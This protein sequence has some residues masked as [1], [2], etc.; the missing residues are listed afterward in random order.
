MEFPSAF[1]RCAGGLGS[2]FF[3]HACKAVSEG[4]TNPFFCRKYESRTIF[5][6]ETS[7]VDDLEGLFDLLTL[8]AR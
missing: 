5:I 2:K 8:F 7:D 4:S 1:F 3:L 6:P